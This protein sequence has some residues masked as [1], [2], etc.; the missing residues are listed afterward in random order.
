MFQIIVSVPCIH[1]DLLSGVKTDNMAST[2][3][4]I[5]CGIRTRDPYHHLEF[6]MLQTGRLWPRCSIKLYLCIVILVRM[7]AQAQNY[8]T[9]MSM[10]RYKRSLIQ[11]LFLWKAHERVLC[12]ST[13]KRVLCLPFAGRNHLFHHFSLI[14]EKSK[15]F[16]QLEGEGGR[17]HINRK[18]GN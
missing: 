9:T 8:P 10:K 11:I 6:L 2:Q 5:P 13:R 12:I 17:S 3:F 15:Q 4:A 18:D 1:D 16:L 14:S 7:A